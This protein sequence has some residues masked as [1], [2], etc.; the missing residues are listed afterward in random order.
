MTLKREVVDVLRSLRDSP[1]SALLVVLSLATGLAAVL[2]MLGVLDVLFLRAPAGVRDAGRVV[3][4][5]RWV[6]QDA[7]SY[8]DFQDIA[9]TA[10]SFE[11]VGAFSTQDFTARIGSRAVPVRGML[12]SASLGPTLGTAVASGRWFVAD[13]DRPGAAPVALVSTRFAREHFGGTDAGS[14][15][16][17]AIGTSLFTVIG[18]LPPDF[19]APDLGEVDLVLPLTNTPWFGG[20]RALTSRSYRYLR[21]V[22]RLRPDISAQQASSE[23]T[24]ASRQRSMEQATD[25]DDTRRSQVVP[26][27]S[28]VDARRDPASPAARISL[29]VSLLAV[30]VLLVGII[31]AL[32]LVLVRA[33]RGRKRLAILIALG[34]PRGILDARAIG[35]AVLLAL[36]AVAVALPLAGMTWQAVVQGA[37]AGR[38]L[39]PAMTPRLAVLVVGLACIAAVVTALPKLRLVRMR[40]LHAELRSGAA[41]LSHRMRR[42]FRLLL[43]A[44]ISLAVVLVSEAAIFVV[45]LRQ[46]A[47]VRLG[48][49]PD[50]L[51]VATIDLRA[52]GLA[53]ADAEVVVTRLLAEA[54]RIPGARSA[55]M[56]NAALSPA[57]ITFP[58][59][60]PGGPEL[61]NEDD[62]IASV[63]MVTTDFLAAVGARVVAGRDFTV[64]DG[65]GTSVLVSSR[66]AN[67]RWPGASA[68]GQCVKLGDAS[69]PCGLVVGVIE[70]RRESPTETRG[71][72]E[73]F[74]PAA[75]PIV[76]VALRGTF[77]ARELAL[78][79]DGAPERAVGAL[80]D[81][82]TRVVPSLTAV[83]VRTGEQYL[84]AQYR[85][86]RLG[87]QIVGAFGLIAVLL[88]GIGVYGVVTHSTLSRHRELSIRK[89]LGADNGSILMLVLG[90]S[91]RI[92][93]A[94]IVV[95]LC[96]S[97]AGARLTQH[98]AYGVSLLD[99][100]LYLLPTLL[101]LAVA[102]LATLPAAWR[103]SRVSASRMLH[104]E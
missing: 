44:Q 24:V 83:R 16:T 91:A 78:R 97:V 101:L 18:V 34:V 63:S 99:A 93:A 71:S 79:V 14:G 56:T 70:D 80:Q 53:P 100:R 84:S 23:M 69:A 26:V 59:V 88:A 57:Y 62:A 75:S 51:L 2:T 42:A 12:T 1:G 47:Q 9:E 76:P 25:Q 39:A 28:L 36:L 96:G 103:G 66:F 21:L 95:G 17:L 90:E 5:G 68:M 31:N 3:A 46:A 8:P 81:A 92:A 82:V 49:R 37:L 94:G 13:D 6:G 10:R 19:T 58:V 38:V 20:A 65:G 61:R 85:A 4:V 64:G 11:S 86:W 52:A 35:E 50:H 22:A 98:L 7:A 60:T 45:S 41:S 40:G 30:A 43:V 77:L 74:V 87:A 48:V 54:T 102:L 15:R 104:G 27:A 67:M 29:W 32:A 73:V 89:V 72:A 33:T 55:G